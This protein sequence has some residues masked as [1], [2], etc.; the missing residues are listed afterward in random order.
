MGEGR[1]KKRMSLEIAD[2]TRERLYDPCRSN[3]WLFASIEPVEVE[4]GG[5][6][7]Y[8][9]VSTKMCLRK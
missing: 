5:A 3:I 6:E 8:W 7:M 9:I 4:L 1:E 2:A